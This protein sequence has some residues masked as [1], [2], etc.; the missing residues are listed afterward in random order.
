MT[1]PLSLLHS[2]Q[3]MVA[4][5][6]DVPLRLNVTEFLITD[7]D[8]LPERHRNCASEEQVLVAHDP[9]G[10]RIGV[11][12]D[13]QLLERLA[14][15]NPMQAL[16]G[17]NLGDFWTALE[18]VSHFH[19]LAWNAEHGRPVTLHEL[20]LQAEV[21]KYVSS[22]WLLRRQH[23]QR[24]PVELHHLLFD[25]FRLHTDLSAERRQL[26]LDANSHAARF[27]RRI[28]QRLSS[29]LASARIETL[30]ELRRFY[31]LTHQRKFRHVDHGA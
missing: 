29:S 18:G 16:S 24:F 23:P 14:L 2:L 26:Y 20:E 15:A 8:H 22:L 1:H 28:A 31:R 21:D 4:A 9:E 19:Y 13:S 27:C 17:D 25:R 6:Y 30:A 12:L 7:R 5:I 10:L 3:Q 11:F